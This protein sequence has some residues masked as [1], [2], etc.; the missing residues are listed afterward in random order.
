MKHIQ[1][2][3]IC[4]LA[5]VLSLNMAAQEE[6]KDI[7]H[8]TRGDVLELTY[9]ELLEMP[10][11][12]L[13]KLADIV[14]VSIDELYEMILNKDVISASKKA[15]SSFEAP[16]S[17]SVISYDEIKKSGST[18]IEEALRLVPGV[19]VRQK[20][21][22]N[23][24]LHIRGND[25]V[26]PGNMLLYS[27]NS[28]S[29]IMIDNRVVY[30]YAHG[31]AFWETLPIGLED[32]DRIEV[33]RGPSSALYGPNAVSGVIHIITKRF[34]ENKTHVNA[35]IQ[36]GLPNSII[37]SMNAGTKITEDFWVNLSANYH[38]RDRFTDE[39]Y[40]WGKGIFV[41]R[42][43]LATFTTTV[44]GNE[45][46]YERDD[47]NNRYPDPL[48]GR[49]NYGVNLNLLYDL[50]ENIKFDL[51]GG[52]QNSNVI[53]TPIDN[54]TY[55]YTRRISESQYINFRSKLY[56]L[57]TQ[58]SYMYGPQD[59]ALNKPGMQYDFKTLDV[60]AEYDYEWKGLGIRP[61]ISYRQANYDDGDYVDVIAKEG[62]LN[63][64]QKLSTFSYGLRLDYKLFDN[65]RLIGAVRGDK[66]NYPNKTY[67]TYQVCASSNI[68]DKHL[69]RGV[70]SRANRSPFIV[71]VYADFDWNKPP[72][73]DMQ[74][75]GLDYYLPTGGHIYFE[76]NKDLD[77][78]TMDMIE[79][80]YR[81][82][83]IK[84]VQI[85]LEG[86]YTKTTNFDWFQLDTLN[87]LSLT[88][89]SLLDMS[90]LNQTGIPYYAIFSYQNLNVV[91]KQIGVS[92]NITTVLNEKLYF[93]VFGTL[94]QTKLENHKP[95]TVTESMTV[96]STNAA[97]PSNLIALPDTI[98]DFTNNIATLEHRFGGSYLPDSTVSIP[99][100]STPK[101]YGGLMVNYRPIDK[102]NINA[103]VYSYTDQRFVQSYETGYIGPK[104]I[105][106][107]K[108][109]YKVYKENEIYLNCRNLFNN[110]KREFA[111]L[112]G[113]EGM[114][115]LGLSIH[116]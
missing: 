81:A 76:G 18:T 105:T 100:K 56:G 109:S 65:L 21:N 23:F 68:N 79:I 19:I 29:L 16:L 62:F 57:N 44:G 46:V 37:G 67:L 51:T 102:L 15:E 83:P 95:L 108:V 71:D 93:K 12:D 60:I 39:F 52:Y 32:I 90:V 85:D 11:E 74:P 41:P 80:G 112:E 77:L 114:Y 8:M 89:V 48:L 72:V 42:D 66:Y 107:L 31:G 78:A 94:Q 4:L 40:L 28:M 49:K 33:V 14:G 2:I 17:T 87:L 9:D 91:S 61:G 25:N 58:F 75:L 70:Y 10:F 45:E 36:G 13:L 30:N 88:T 55:P 82:K 34:E 104:I 6:G 101:F 53:T 27:E 38:Y 99:H 43:S 63:G 106:N 26:P 84:Q 92:F 59:V 22:G 20:T 116:F 111:F 73:E 98:F 50:N 103:S 47:V 115:M 5:I 1:Y 3:F 7:S 113:V 110:K 86:F 97:Q 35:D 54:P 64:D 24:D 96:M 69:I